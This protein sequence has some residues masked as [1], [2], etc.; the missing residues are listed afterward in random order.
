MGLD[1]VASGQILSGGHDL[2]TRSPRETLAAGVGYVP[3]DRVR[4]GLIAD[5][6][7]AENLVLDIYYLPPFAR[8]PVLQPDQIRRSAEERIR[9]FDIRTPS[10]L[11]AA[12]NLS[13]GNQQRVIVAREFTRPVSLMIASQ[14]TRGLDVGSIEY[15][16]ERIVKLRDQGDAVLIVSSDLD[17]VIALGDRIAV[18]YQGRMDG[19]FDSGTQTRE[20]IGLMMAGAGSAV[21][22]ALPRSNER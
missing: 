14:P 11:V 2:T 6:S 17:E 13:G 7:V 4:D 15:I 5:F 10:P 19:P 18:M 21:D 3:E 20:Q 16:H 22:A 1:H 12:G 8:G 9:E